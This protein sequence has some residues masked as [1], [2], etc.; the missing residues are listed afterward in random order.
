MRWLDRKSKRFIIILG[1][2]VFGLVVAADYSSGPHLDLVI[3]YLLPVALYSWYLGTRY[4]LV[5]SAACAASNYFC[6]TLNVKDTPFVIGLWNVGVELALLVSVSYA[7]AALHHKEETQE[8]LTEFIVHDLRSPMTNLL[9]GMQTLQMLAADKFD[10]TETELVDMAITS[11]NRLITLINS[12][13]DV[14]RLEN[15]QMPLRLREVDLAAL[16]QSSMNNVSLWADQ[17]S[18]IMKPEIDPDAPKVHID[19]DLTERV[20]INLLSNALKFSP[21]GSTITVG[22]KLVGPHDLRF[23][24]ADQGPGI[25]K[26][27]ARKIFDKFAQI[28]ARKAGAA[29]TGLGLSFCRSAVEVQGG[30]IWVESEIGKGST[31]IFSLPA[32]THE[33]KSAK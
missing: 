25:P 20:L 2:I 33:P 5:M 16:V 13:L 21:S 31:F 18:V 8:E 32:H 30:H 17:N 4:G 7:L 3:F 22:A 28:E 9:T 15:R 23:S 24:V 27:W 29:S 19:A 6:T 1:I 10:K 14:A 12:L 26:E 11:S